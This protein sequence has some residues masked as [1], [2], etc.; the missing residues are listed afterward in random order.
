MVGIDEEDVG[1]EVDDLVDDPA[2]V[3]GDDPE[4]GRERGREQR[5]GGTE[6]QR[7]PCSEH[8][9]REDVASLV[10]R[11]E[12]VVPRR[13]LPG[14]EDVEVGRVCDGDPRGDQRDERP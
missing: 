2:R 8:D 4:H 1:Q 9:L 12:Q 6:D 10:G 7:A 14:G 5:G 13:R 11:S 3:R